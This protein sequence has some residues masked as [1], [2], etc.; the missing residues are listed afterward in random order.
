ML[1]DYGVC[2]S[3]LSFAEPS[4]GGSGKE[5]GPAL[6]LSPMK[7]ARGLSELEVLDGGAVHQLAVV[8]DQAGEADLRPEALTDRS[9]QWR[10]D[11]PDPV[12]AEVA[13][14]DHLVA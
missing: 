7:L 13:E 8:T 14:Q 11:L 4:I 9:D 1:C 2:S 10:A 6:R 3:G 12:P 5:R